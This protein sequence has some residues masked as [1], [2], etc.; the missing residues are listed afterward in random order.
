MADKLIKSVQVRC[1]SNSWVSEWRGWLAIRMVD[2]QYGCVL[3]TRSV[4]LNESESFQ[5]GS[6]NLTPCI[7][8]I[9]PPPSRI[10][11]SLAIN[12]RQF[13]NCASLSTV[14]FPHHPGTPEMEARSQLNAKKWLLK[15][16]PRYADQNV[17]CSTLRLLFRFLFA[18]SCLSFSI[19][20]PSLPRS[21]KLELLTKKCL[22]RSPYQEVLSDP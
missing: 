3:C 14:L 4:L 13:A 21:S 15:R 17:S 8:W 18:A 6:A 9:P 19:E 16:K 22:P 7:Y 5:S 1:S 2:Y 11:S 20:L 12:R 10:V